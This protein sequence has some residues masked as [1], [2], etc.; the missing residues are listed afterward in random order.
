MSKKKRTLPKA[1][2]IACEGRST[3]K[4][5]FQMIG[6]L[7]GDE[8]NYALTIYPDENEA[9]PKSDPLGL[10]NEAIS[11]KDEGFD[12]LW[13]VFDK[14]GYTKHEDAFKLA[15]DNDINI[16]FSSIA[17]EEWVL[18]HF[19]RFSNKFDKSDCK[20]EK[21]KY[22]ECGSHK[23][24]G[25]CSGERCV[26]GYMREHKLFSDYSK[27]A[28]KSIYPFL[29]NKTETAITNSAWLRFI[30]REDIRKE[31]DQLFNINPYT[32]VDVL[33]KRLTG[34]DKNHHYFKVGDIIDDS[35]IHAHIHTPIPN[36]IIAVITSKGEAS[37]VVNN[38]NVN[39]NFSIKSKDKQCPI[40]IRE[41]CVVEPGKKAVINIYTTSNLGTDVEIVMK[42]GGN[43][44]YHILK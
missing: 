25:D 2:F 33:V 3:E 24:D 37:I 9:K 13:A 5:Y 14:D 38:T 6:E 20:N 26:A 21:E 7:F 28:Y 1:I 40:S 36:L 39:D 22:L 29:E 4:N 19:G 30:M 10:I 12:E 41:T 16:A 44:Y 23:N 34:Y 43:D 18:M 8:L 31:K 11:R 15:K 17:F 32:D 27:S 35:R 42:W